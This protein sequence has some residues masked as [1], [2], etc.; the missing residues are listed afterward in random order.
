[1]KYITCIPFQR[2]SGAKFKTPE[3][4]NLF[5]SFFITNSNEQLLGLDSPQ[6]VVEW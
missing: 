4:V 6:V 1:M 3:C 5:P 2:K